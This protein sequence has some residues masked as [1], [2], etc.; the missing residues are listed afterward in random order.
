MKV[1]YLGPQSSGAIKMLVF[2]SSVLPYVCT[3]IQP[4]ASVPSGILV[5]FQ[6]SFDVSRIPYKVQGGGEKEAFSQRSHFH[7]LN[8]HQG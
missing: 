5:G 6:T 3:P 2:F 8:Y 7:K 4:D 1:W